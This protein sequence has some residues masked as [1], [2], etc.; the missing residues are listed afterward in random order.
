[1][2][3]GEKAYRH[4]KEFSEEENWTLRG[5]EVDLLR[6]EEYTKRRDIFARKE[7]RNTLA[8]MQNTGTA[9]EF[10]NS[11]G[12][13]TLYPALTEFYGMNKHTAFFV[14]VR[15]LEQGINIDLWRPGDSINLTADGDLEVVQN[16]AETTI[17]DVLLT[18]GEVSPAD[19]S[20]AE[21]PPAAPAPPPSGR[22]SLPPPGR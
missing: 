11:A 19:R 7:G 22:P 9:Y 21:E 13:K 5:T 14:M 6:L 10:E 20:P 8:D 15:M 2:G 17:E 4:A 3:H 1:M 18:P 12:K 16:G